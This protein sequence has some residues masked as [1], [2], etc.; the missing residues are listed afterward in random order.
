MDEFVRYLIAGGVGGGVGGGG[1]GAF[2][3]F[4]LKRHLGKRDALEAKLE[5]EKQKA[6]LRVETKIDDHLKSDNPGKTEEQLNKL[7]GEVTRLSD[8]ID[9]SQ[10]ASARESRDVERTLG[11]IDGTLNGIGLWLKNMNETVQDHIK[12][13]GK[14]GGK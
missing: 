11:K 6:L 8:K 9:R 2:L 3:F 13:G 1:I 7:S 5:E 12:D 4:L 10:E 14:H